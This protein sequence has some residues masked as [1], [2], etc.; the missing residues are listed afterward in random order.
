MRAARLARGCSSLSPR[1]CRHR[2]TTTND[3]SPSA[4]NCSSR[5]ASTMV[6]GSPNPINRIC[7]RR[8]IPPPHRNPRVFSINKIFRRL[9][10]C[11]SLDPLYRRHRRH[12]PATRPP[13]AAGLRLP[14][15]GCGWLRDLFLIIF[16]SLGAPR[17]SAANC[18]FNVHQIIAHAPFR[19][20]HILSSPP[21]PPLWFGYRCR[22]RA[23]RLGFRSGRGC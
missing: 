17:L 16:W 20:K 19:P 10:R 14:N 2:R 11:S 23:C 1:P 4:A 7:Q 9:R 21:L 5:R 22:L 12:H 15:K 18:Q 13:T 6:L 8:A 3:E